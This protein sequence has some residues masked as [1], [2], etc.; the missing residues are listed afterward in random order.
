M[1]VSDLYSGMN[2][3]TDDNAEPTSSRVQL[4]RARR[5]EADMQIPR[6]IH[7][8]DFS[9]IPHTEN[10]PFPR[11]IHSDG[12]APPRVMH[13]DEHPRAPRSEATPEAASSLAAQVASLAEQ[14]RDL[15][16]QAQSERAEHLRERAA[17]ERKL[18]QSH[19]MLSD[20]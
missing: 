16:L 17:L 11:V 14:L 8:D 2:T 7:S 12:N 13:S 4:S 1:G 19:N 6:V 10:N 15:Q 3:D 9:R 20:A 18:E 5:S